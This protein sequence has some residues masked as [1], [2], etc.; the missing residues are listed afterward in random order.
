M[1]FWAGV[2]RWLR[3]W[4]ASDEVKLAGLKRQTSAQF[5]RAL[6]DYRAGTEPEDMAGLGGAFTALYDELCRR[7]GTTDNNLFEEGDRVCFYEQA[8]KLSALGH[9]E[10]D[11]W[12]ALAPIRL[13]V[14]G[15]LLARLQN[16]ED[17]WLRLCAVTAALASGQTQP[18]LES[19]A[20]IAQDPFL[21]DLAWRW[22]NRALICFP[23]FNPRPGYEKFLAAIARPDSWNVQG[24]AAPPDRWVLLASIY[25]D[26]PSDPRTELRDQRILAS[27][28]IQL[29]RDWDIVDR[30]SAVEVLE[31]LRTEGHRAA[32][33][34]DLDAPNFEGR[35]AHARFVAANRA[36][37]SRHRILAWD[38]ARLVAVARSAYALGYL[39]EDEVGELLAWAGESLR[40]TYDSWQ[41][42]GADYNLGAGYFEP[43][44][45]QFSAH[46][47]MVRWL[48]ED[49]RSPWR[50]VSF[51]GESK[52][53]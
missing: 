41:E 6:A 31:W 38:C 34:S 48:Q 18:A 21:S 5:D 30:E 24:G 39:D 22:A 25:P 49:P 1:K 47:A 43:E 51:G 26:L 23:D 11:A 32:L 17:P 36:A 10:H 44:N 42:F 7:N 14:L 52:L 9:P 13:Q 45:T 15:G 19:Y 35:P 2:R 37:L 8:L 28:R 27:Q 46:E 29:E 50:R 20:H 53:N 16:G 40:E 33:A 4:R 3:G 12:P